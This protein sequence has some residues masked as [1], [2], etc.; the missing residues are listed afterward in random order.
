MLFQADLRPG[1]PE[2]IQKLFWEL[3]EADAS[4]RKFSDWLFSTTLA[5]RERIDE[6][7]CRHSRNWKLNRMA[8]V[9]RNVLRMAVSEV[10]FSQT[11]RPV[12]IDEAIE[13]ARRFSTEESADFVN[14]VL[15][16]ICS[17]LQQPVQG[18]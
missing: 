10:L 4:T 16:A 5:H 17:E 18:A 9:D 11:P 1:Q 7:I 13:I 2:E 6:L 14:G 15:D 12:V 8:A 3:K